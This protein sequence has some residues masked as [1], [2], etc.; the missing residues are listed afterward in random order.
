MIVDNAINSEHYTDGSIDLVHMSVNSIDSDQYVDASID[1][2]HLA[3][4]AVGLDE[5]SA[6]G[7]PSSSNFLRGDNAWAAAGG[8]AWN[9][10][11]T[12]V[13]S[14][15][16][17]LTITGLDSTYDCYAIII[18]D[19]VPATDSAIPELQMGDSSGVDVGGT[20]YSFHRQSTY[21]GSTSYY[22]TVSAGADHIDIGN[23]TG[24]TAD[25]GYGCV[26]YLVRPG[27]GAVNPIITGTSVNISA[28]ADESQGGIIVGCRTAVITVDRILFQFSAGNIVSGRMTVYGV[29]HA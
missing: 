10:I 7:T 29:A 21:S 4:D 28:S 23:F 3:D 22:A 19:A 17:S 26:L 15:S 2:A 1:N 5:L 13:A 20:D 8:G 16:A 25:E 6:T 18:S 24:S 9:I 12:S 27:D 11:G 14:T